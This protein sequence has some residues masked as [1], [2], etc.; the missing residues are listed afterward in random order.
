MFLP[1]D[2]VL[3][4]L[5]LDYPRDAHRATRNLPCGGAVGTCP[6]RWRLAQMHVAH[7][8]VMSLADVALSIRLIE[9]ILAFHGD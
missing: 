6:P 8:T 9:L 7:Q 2:S 3:T 5:R 1:I 4:I